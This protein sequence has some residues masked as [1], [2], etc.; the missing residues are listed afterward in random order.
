MQLQEK[1]GED[2]FN[3]MPANSKLVVYG[4]L[5][6]E[7]IGVSAGSLIFKEKVEGFW[8]SYWIA[9]T[10]PEEFSGNS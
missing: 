1:T 9:D 10:P 7:P 2:N 5:S 3:M 6:E 8:L 4:A